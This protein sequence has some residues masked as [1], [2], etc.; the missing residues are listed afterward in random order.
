MMIRPL[1]DGFR[2]GF[3]GDDVRAVFVNAFANRDK[4][5][6]FA[7]AALV[8]FNPKRKDRFEVL[9]SEEK[10]S[11]LNAESPGQPAGDDS[12]VVPTDSAVAAVLHI[13]DD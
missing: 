13:D 8:R 12:D 6:R 1:L 11:I 7:K 3:G 4:T 10:D 9:S 5:L 2:N